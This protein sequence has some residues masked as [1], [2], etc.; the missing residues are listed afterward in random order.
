MDTHSWLIIAAVT[1]AAF[2]AAGHAV[3]YKRDP[4]AAFGWV[5]VCLMF[6]LAGP[7]LYF[8]FGINRIHTRARKLHRIGRSF[9]FN[10]GYERLDTE[11]GDPL[12]RRDLPSAFADIARVSDSVTRRPLIAGNHVEPLENGEQAYPAMLEEIDRARD[13]VYLC[14]YIFQADEIGRRFIDALAGAKARGVDVRVIVDGIGERYSF[15]RTARSL[16]RKHGISVGRFLPPTLFPPTLYINLRTHRKVLCC[17]GKVGFIGGMNIADRHLVENPKNR[18][19][20]HDVHFRVRGPVVEQMIETFLEDWNFCTGRANAAPSIDFDSEPPS[21]DDESERGAV[22]RVIADG[23]NED[24]DKLAAIMMGAI[25]VARERIGIVTPY[26]LPPREMISALQ[27][28]VLRGVQVS[29]VLPSRNNLPYVH[30]ATQN[31]LW[32]VVQ[33]GVG[34]YYQPPPFDHTKLFLVDDFYVQI[35]S[36]N[37][38]PR[39]LRLNFELALE[40]FDKELGAA[41]WSRLETLRARAHRVTLHELDSR[42]LPVRARDAIAWLFS[43]YL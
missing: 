24:L 9:R 35:G 30:W 32:E 38:D 16:M 17:D 36:A 25:S 8:I 22:S 13:T 29:L 33:R 19:P 31:M 10:L 12:E 34:V 42:S 6:P 4:R 3:L 21:G 18:T 1:A 23:P 43:P 7:V 5:A 14:T 26:F 39:S 27:T 41:L 37:M 20:V 40:V 28:A 11:Q 2:L 15:P